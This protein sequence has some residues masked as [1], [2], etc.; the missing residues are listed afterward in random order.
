MTEIVVSMG[1]LLMISVVDLRM[2]TGYLE[3]EK[4]CYERTFN[5]LGALKVN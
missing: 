5:S 4:H 3:A 2:M 1:L